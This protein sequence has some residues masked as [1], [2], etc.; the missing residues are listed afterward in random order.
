MASA[1]ATKAR[2]GN[3][4]HR[5]TDYTHVIYSV[6]YQT[7]FMAALSDEIQLFAS[8]WLEW[9]EEELVDPD[10]SRVEPQQAELFLTG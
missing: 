9:L 3:P 6:L 4:I 5:L 10:C 1:R 2:A 8:G 7:V